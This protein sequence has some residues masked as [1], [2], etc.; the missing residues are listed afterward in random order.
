MLEEYDEDNYYARFNTHSYN[1]AEKDINPGLS[2][3]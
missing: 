3:A 1:T 2:G